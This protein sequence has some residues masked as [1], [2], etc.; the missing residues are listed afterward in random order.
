MTIFN[1]PHRRLITKQ[2]FTLRSTA[3]YVVVYF[4]SNSKPEFSNKVYFNAK[5][6][7]SKVYV[8]FCAQK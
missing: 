6:I 4:D 1:D 5:Q 3:I 7:K 8:I 2:Q